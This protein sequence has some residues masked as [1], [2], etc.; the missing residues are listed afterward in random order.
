MAS[1]I[2]ITYIKV[3]VINH[4]FLVCGQYLMQW[5]SV[6]QFFEVSK[7]NFDIASFLW[8][9]L[10]TNDIYLEYFGLKLGYNSYFLTYFLLFRDPARSCSGG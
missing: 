2:A 4:V 3:N 6:Y 8:L 1:K 5:E 10:F 7:M 9:G